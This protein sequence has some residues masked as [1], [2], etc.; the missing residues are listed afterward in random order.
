M[1]KIACAGLIA[2]VPAMMSTSVSAGDKQ[3]YVGVS[4]LVSMV[5]DVDGNN[6]RGGAGEVKTSADMDTSF[7]VAVR[8]GYQFTKFRAEVELGYRD[9]E[10]DSISTASGTFSSS[11]GDAKA[12]TLM[13]NGVYDIKTDGAVTP[14]VMAG[15]GL[16]RADGDI[17]YTDDNGR[18]QTASADGTTF[19]GQIGVG[20]S[21][22]MTPNVDLVGGYSFMGAP[23][24]AT[25][26]S[27]VL[28]I[29]SAQVGV[30]YK[31]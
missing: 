18:A 21:Y 25:G 30:N 14:Y 7:G 29:H 20:A 23:T 8:G 1:K 16:L 28:K 5:G 31:F 4:G 9:I 27:Q 13:V 17:S 19:A 10:V 15:V 22:G 26:D 24:D 6:G 12:Y 11:S 2:L 3:S